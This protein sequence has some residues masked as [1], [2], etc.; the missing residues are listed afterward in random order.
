MTAGLR[1]MQKLHSFSTIIYKIFD[2]TEILRPAL[3]CCK[4]FLLYAK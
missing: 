3:V 4:V 1:K 2:L